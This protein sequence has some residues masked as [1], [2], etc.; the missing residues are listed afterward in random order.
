VFFRGILKSL[1]NPRILIPALAVAMIGVIGWTAHRGIQ[2]QAVSAQWVTHTREVLERMDE[3]MESLVEMQAT[4]RGYVITGDASYLTPFKRAAGR[5]PERINKV[6]K[7]TEDNVNQQQRLEVVKGLMDERVA[8]LNKFIGLYETGGFEVAQRFLAESKVTER[9]AKLHAAVHEMEEEERTLLA[10]RMQRSR[11]T[12]RFSSIVSITGSIIA[13]LTVMIA[14]VSVHRHFKVRM[15]AEQKLQAANTIQQAILDHAGASIISV[16]ETGKICTFNA[17]AQRW[18][19]YR[20]DEV[21]GVETPALFHDADEV[22]RRAEELSAEFNKTIEPGF[23]VF[24]AKSL[25]GQPDEHE[26]TYIARDGRRFPVSLAITALRDETGN[27]T[28]FLGIGRDIT[29]EKKAGEI[30]RASLAEKEVLLREIHHRVKNNLQIISSMLQLQSGYLRDEQDIH[31]FRESQHRIRTMALIHEKLYQSRDMGK[32]DFSEYLRS[33][34]L[35]LFQSY[36]TGP[37]KVQPKLTI[38]PISLGIDTAIPVGLITNELITNS[39]KYAFTN[40][41]AGVVEVACHP[42]ADEGFELVVR[43]NGCGLPAGFDLTKPKSLGL[44]LVK[45]LTTQVGGKVEF[46]TGNGTEFRITFREIS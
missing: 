7:L 25:A 12:A 15:D 18:L 34:V 46:H 5:L 3:L 8:H 4:A 13:A 40:G 22:T 23:D 43:D 28:G 16:D 9:M 21:V 19:G 35:M 24:A 2:I 17:T 36:S 44:R 14:A 42:K 33:L 32:I 27:V 29:E 39:L 37:S 31:M 26:W 38:E 6:Q 1:L 10:K 20:E 30:V 11:E 45:L 41:A